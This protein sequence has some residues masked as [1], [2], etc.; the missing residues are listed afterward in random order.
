MGASAFRCYAR[1]ILALV[2]AISLIS[3][4]SSAKRKPKPVDP[5]DLTPHLYSRDRWK[6]S[7]A[8]MMAFSQGQLKQGRYKYALMYADRGSHSVVFL[9]S[10]IVE[11]VVR[12]DAQNLKNMYLL[13]GYAKHKQEDGD[14]MKAL[15]AATQ[16]TLTKEFGSA[17]REKDYLFANGRG[18]SI[19]TWH[20]PA[21]RIRLYCDKNDPPSYV[22]VLLERPDLPDRDMNT[23]LRTTVTV[24]PHTEA[25]KGRVLA[26]PMFHQLPGL[27]ACDFTTTARQFAYL[28][29][30]IEPMMAAQMGERWFDAMGKRLSFHVETHRFFRLSTDAR[31]NS[32]DLL[33][34]YNQLAVRYGAAPI[35]YRETDEVIGYGDN[36][37][38]MKASILKDIPPSDRDKEKYQQFRNFV[39]ESID[40]CLPVSW[41]VVRS[42]HKEGG[43][44]KHRR[45]IIGY[46]PGRDSISFS[47]PW[48]FNADQREMPFRAAF[49]MTVWVRTIFPGTNG[50]ATEPVVDE[51]GD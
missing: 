36:F 25:G 17:S 46:D 35:K 43:G 20:A 18:F 30:E 24:F 42:Y 28:G 39:I 6:V 11:C 37:M 31:K 27:G 29:S 47:D 13:L 1:A 26:V 9:G 32:A 7:P 16:E 14:R 21:A 34:K 15:F 5:F 8:A 12:L 3:T 4:A 33:E 2:L 10:P 49:A 23:R 45:M 41:T 19:H 50:L 38:H 51:E 22:S 40:Q 44:G 48:G